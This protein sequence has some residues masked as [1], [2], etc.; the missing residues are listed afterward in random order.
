MSL[1][2]LLARCPLE[3]E[4]KL[5]KVSSSLK[6]VY[7]LGP[8]WI[9]G[10][11]NISS[12]YQFGPF[13][14]S[15]AERLLLCNGDR[16]VIFPRAFDVLLYLVERSGSLVE[17]Q[18]LRNS[19]W[20]GA[21]VEDGNICVAIS[22][23]RKALSVDENGQQYIETVPKHGYRF[24]AEVRL[25]TR[26]DSLSGARDEEPVSPQVVEEVFSID[27]IATDVSEPPGQQPL[28][29]PAEPGS[30]R[31]P[32][33]RMDGISHWLIF[34][35]ALLIVA[36]AINYPGRGWPK[37]HSQVLATSTVPIHSLG[38]LPFTTVGEGSDNGYL[39]IGM[40]TEV[41][42]KLANLGKVLV[43]PS[44]SMAKYASTRDPE[45]VGREQHV[46]AVLDGQVRQVGS[47]VR[48][49]VQLI[50]A[51]DGGLIWGDK[52]DEQYTNIF[53]V[54]DAVSQAVA[55]SILQTLTPE[56]RKLLSRHSTINMD[57][58]EAYSKGTF[59]M[60]KRTNASLEKALGYYGQAVALDPNYAEAYAGTADTYA[61]LGLYTG[62]PPNQAFP[63]AK[64]AA[65]KALLLNPSLA[66]PH[67]T[68]GF[69]SF[70]H[71]WDGT[72]AEE[73]FKRSLSI[74]SDDPIAHTWSGLALVILGRYGEAVHEATVAI[75]SDPLSPVVNTNAG[76]VLS[77]AGH[78][79]E[80]ITAFRNAIE[81]DPE[82]PR[83]HYRLGVAYMQKQMAEQA[84]AE[85]RSA[86]RLSDNDPYYEAALGQAYAISGNVTKSRKILR[87]L[88]KETTNRYVPP[89]AVAQVY[90]GLAD[91]DE[92]FKWLNSAY[93]DKSTSMVYLKVDPSLNNLRSDPRFSAL[94]HRLNF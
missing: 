14:L 55:E 60:N 67:T 39:G 87:H 25:V 47:H 34:A 28:H 58:Y 24:V 50:R 9:V 21:F 41:T 94:T 77:L 12:A 43:R 44:S 63:E 46:D 17:K 61:L 35:A 38:V 73:E 8:Q 32:L 16:V 29:V 90:A 13:E 88:I 42:S 27:Q 65:V 68:L 84:L 53:E 6:I 57:A 81:M 40:S 56:D 75:K 91:K 51:S 93:E 86:V 23:L 52:F 5:L 59:F 2:T 30:M 78:T 69:V 49:S 33:L 19:V 48:L 45:A 37:G 70:Y 76:F 64:K 7:N 11:S 31:R 10:A 54:Q 4:V 15:P 80:A 72:V 20:D 79:D 18:D 1:A 26:G 92:A 3:K 83:A 36:G 66:G 89:F 82:F 71:D 85:L 74:T 62:L 22:M